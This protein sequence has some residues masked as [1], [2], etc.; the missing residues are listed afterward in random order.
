M[1]SNEGFARMR[2][3]AVVVAVLLGLG[4][5]GAAAAPALAHGATTTPISR[6]AACG[7]VGT[8]DAPVCQAARAAGGGGEIDWPNLRLPNVNGRDRDV[9]PDGRLCSAGKPEFA[10]LDL[11][12]SDWPVTSLKSGKRLEFRYGETIPHKGTFRLYLTKD[13]YDPSRRLRWDDLDSTPFASVTDPPLIDEAYRFSATLPARTGRHMIYAIW[14]NSSTPDTYYSCSDVLLTAA[15]AQKPRAP[16]AAPAPPAAPSAG[17]RPE[18]TPP[19]AEETSVAP[20]APSAEPAPG[21]A[22]AAQPVSTERS[23]TVPLLVGGLFAAFALAGAV[24]VVSRRRS[25]QSR[26]RHGS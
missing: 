8:P 16:Q 24:F 18:E 21:L 11:V 17:S 15:S 22:R 1:S 13:G 19:P 4:S 6:A 5:A 23:L 2:L 26:G 10:G 3:H 12:R 9:V 14:Q 25:G 20:A 7:E